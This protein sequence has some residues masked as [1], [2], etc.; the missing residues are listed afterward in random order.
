[1]G[2]ELHSTPPDIWVRT[3]AAEQAEEGSRPA[4][5]AIGKSAPPRTRCGHP[6]GKCAHLRSHALRVFICVFVFFLSG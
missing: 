1:M 5:K 2:D 6:P 4:H 3:V